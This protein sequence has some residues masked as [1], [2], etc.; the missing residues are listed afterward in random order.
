MAAVV[1]SRDDLTRLL[2]ATAA[3]VA[4][5]L[6]YAAVVVNLYRPAWD[7]YEVVVA[8]DQDEQARQE[9]L[10][11]RVQPAEL[12]KLLDERFRRH[13]A[14]LVP[15]D[16][17]DFESLDMTWV[18]G[19]V[20]GEGPDAWHPDDALLVPLTASDGRRLAFLSLDEPLDGRRPSDAALEVLSAVAAHRGRASSSTPSSR[21]RRRATAPRSSTCCASRPS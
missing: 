12:D 1:R 15:H 8:E 3:T 20:A 18:T 2:E 7:D 4:Q 19:S 9:L 11:R 6:G 21:P 17:F 14:F 13:G 16:Q 10:G 5:E